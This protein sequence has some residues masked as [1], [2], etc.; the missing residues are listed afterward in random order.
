MFVLQLTVL[1]HCYHKVFIFFFLKIPICFLSLRLKSHGCMDPVVCKCMQGE[2]DKP[3]IFST[4]CQTGLKR[5]TCFPDGIN[6]HLRLLLKKRFCFPPIKKCNFWISLR[7][8]IPAM[9]VLLSLVL[10]NSCIDSAKKMT[11]KDKKYM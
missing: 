2:S 1:C 5:P 9:L 8:D 6:Y 4:K 11:P 7:V 3:K 10:S